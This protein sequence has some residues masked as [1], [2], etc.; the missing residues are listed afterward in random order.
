MKN[1]LVLAMAFFS[2]TFAAA[3]V[4][5]S[6]EKIF[7]T[8]DK[9]IDLNDA[10]TI[11]DGIIFIG[12]TRPADK[13]VDGKY[14]GMRVQKQRRYYQV[15]GNCQSY[16]SCLLFRRAPQGATKDHKVIPSLKPRSCMVKFKPTS[17]GTLTF[18]AMT[19]KA[20]GNNLYVAVA[21][22]KEFHSLAILPAVIATENLG[23]K[24]DTPISPLSCDYKYKKGDE[25][26]I[27][28][29]GSVILHAFS[30]SGNIDK[31]FKGNQ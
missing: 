24:K 11:K 18:C 12:D 28:S 27:Y 3:Q 29:D 20:E 1:L 5:V 16:N 10:Q 7:P 4:E 14:R 9:L 8:E 2:A 25:I 23:R 30:F 22:E 21:N 15:N 17:D 31:N 13:I 19:N 6:M 26:W